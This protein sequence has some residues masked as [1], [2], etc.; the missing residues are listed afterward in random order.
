M[1]QRPFARLVE[2]REGDFGSPDSRIGFATTGTKNVWDRFISIDGKPAYHVGNV[3]NTCA[4]FFERLEGANRSI[5]EIAAVEELASGLRSLDDHAV[6]LIGH[7]LPNGRYVACLMDIFVQLVSPGSESD[8]FAQEQI[9]LWGV[10]GF[11]GMPHNPHTE[12]YR[13]GTSRTRESA[14]LF[15]FLVPMFPSSWLRPGDIERHTSALKDGQT[16]TAVSIGILDIKQPAVWA[17]DP[18]VNEHWCLA[19]Y[20][21]DG[22]HKTFAALRAQKPLSLLSF[23]SLSSGVATEAEVHEAL[24][25]LSAL[26]GQEDR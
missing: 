4:F 11:W 25:G 12:Y 2:L 5:S 22:H 19:H 20:L 13:L 14:G 24:S 9:S 3:C 23:V 15:Q 8:Y 17:G 26:N 6:R 18:P 10:D 16:P 21:L 7:H 1:D